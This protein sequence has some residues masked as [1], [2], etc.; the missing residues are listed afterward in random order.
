MQVL[1][2]RKLTKYIIISIALLLCAIIAILSGV[3]LFYVV[4]N[5]PV[6]P[7]ANATL[8]TTYGA[9]FHGSTYRYTDY[10]KVEDMHS[11]AISDD[12]TVVT[13]DSTKPHGSQANPFVVDSISK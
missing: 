9:L 5:T 12:T 13:V 4:E 1:K 10:T 2:K 7:M 3:Q 6:T 11:G 8:N